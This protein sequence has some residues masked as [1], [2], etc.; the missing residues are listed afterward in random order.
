MAKGEGGD[1]QLFERVLVALDGSAWAEGALPHAGA[2]AGRLGATL[3]LVSV[4]PDE[5]A[6]ERAARLEE[7]KAGLAVPTQVTVEGGDDPAAVIVG[8]VDAARLSES[9]VLVCMT[10]RARRMATAVWGS[11]AVA[12]VR[13]GVAPAL[14]VGPDAHGRPPI[15][16]PVLVALDGSELGES[17]LGLAV[18]WAQAMGVSLEL[19][20]VLDPATV[21]AL[22]EAGIAP[23]DVAEGAYLQRVAERLGGVAR[24]WDVLHGED[25][26]GAIV[27]AAAD[28]GAGWV[29]MATHGR[30]GARLAAAGSVTLGVVHEVHCP[31][32]VQRPGGLTEG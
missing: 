19:R 23:S 10:T 27:Q 9:P 22:A 28:I 15:D 31:V 4:A 8:L 2:V 1:R 26:A 30:T 11:T 6:A 5:E 32:L 20:Q 18:D 12:V 25:P 17:V 13:E 21:E 29:V 16:G 7:L 3:W 14:L 24:N